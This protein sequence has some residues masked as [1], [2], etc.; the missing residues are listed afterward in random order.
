MSLEQ[1]LF[2]IGTSVLAAALF[3]WLL[4]STPRK[5]VLEKVI[6]NLSGRLPVVISKREHR[7]LKKI[8]HSEAFGRELI[9][10]LVAPYELCHRLN[11]T[12]AAKAE[13]IRK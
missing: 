12:S 1:I 13:E 6:C 5:E 11:S 2:S 4:K 10:E 8:E 9:S 3:S 7:R